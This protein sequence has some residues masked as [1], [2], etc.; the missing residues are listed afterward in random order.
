MSFSDL[1]LELVDE[2][3]REAVRVCRISN[4]QMLRLRLVNHAFDAAVE[5]TAWIAGAF[6]HRFQGIL[7]EP[8]RE[9]K[10][11]W[12]RYIT[13]RTL[14]PAARL[15]RPGGHLRLLRDHAELALHR[16]HGQQ[17]SDGVTAAQFKECVNEMC[18][19]LDRQ[20]GVSRPGHAIERVADESFLVVAAHMTDLELARQIIEDPIRCNY[21]EYNSRVPEMK[22]L[23]AG[24]ITNW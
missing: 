20:P 9:R 12:L 14:R 15:P 5:R 8:T 3:V 24:R 6:D 19:L 7:S 13:R 16:L 1:P 22:F 2:I 23:E 17:S 4:K 10:A 21:S 18:R 11:F